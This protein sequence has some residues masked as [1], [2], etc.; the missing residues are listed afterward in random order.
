MLLSADVEA[1]VL[2]EVEAVTEE[3]GDVGCSWNS[4]RGVSRADKEEGVL[5]FTTTPTIS[6]GRR[7][8][9]SPVSNSGCDTVATE[10][11]KE[12]AALCAR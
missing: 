5:T 12:S 7:R 11:T 1:C 9:S 10:G 6:T 4:Q 2:D 3:F 8:P